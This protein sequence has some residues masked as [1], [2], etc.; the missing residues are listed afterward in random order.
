MTYEENKKIC[1]K[2]PPEIMYEGLR[3]LVATINATMRRVVEPGDE[4]AANDEARVHEIAY[5]IVHSMPPREI[6]YPTVYT[7]LQYIR[8]KYK[9]R[10]TNKKWTR[11]AKE[12]EELIAKGLL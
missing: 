6:N 3:E 2:F 5:T 8:D 12:T 7:E 10:P 11:L 9:D 1:D 4:E